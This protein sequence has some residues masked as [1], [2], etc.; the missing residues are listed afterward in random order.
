MSD[1]LVKKY[2]KVVKDAQETFCDKVNV[3]FVNKTESNVPLLELL[4]FNKVSFLV[5]KV[6][7]AF[8]TKA[9]ILFFNYLIKLIDR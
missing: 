8:N 7:T 4:S 9:K 2:E 3:R 6:M 5:L 1:W